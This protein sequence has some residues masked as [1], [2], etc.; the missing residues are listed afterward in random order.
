LED[1]DSLKTAFEGAYG[2]FAVTNFW[3]LFSGEREKE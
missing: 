3:E 1:V 2:V